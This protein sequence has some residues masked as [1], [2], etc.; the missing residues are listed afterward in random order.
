[1]QQGIE[2]LQQVWRQALQ[3]DAPNVSAKDVLDRLELKYK[4][5]AKTANPNRR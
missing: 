5:L 1:L 3:D 2:E 4:A